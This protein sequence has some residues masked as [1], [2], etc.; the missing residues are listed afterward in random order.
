MCSVESPGTADSICVRVARIFRMIIEQFDHRI[1]TQDA[2]LGY[3][4]FLHVF[5]IALLHD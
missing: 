2:V 3:V 1:D 5:K 4:Q